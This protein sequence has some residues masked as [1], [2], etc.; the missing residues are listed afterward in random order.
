M[1]KPSV[2]RGDEAIFCVLIGHLG[3]RVGIL[4]AK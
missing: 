4:S 3:E 1:P 2:M